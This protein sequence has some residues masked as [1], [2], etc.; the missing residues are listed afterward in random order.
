[1]YN[2]SCLAFLSNSFFIW[3]LRTTCICTAASSLLKNKVNFAVLNLPEVGS[4]DL[5]V[6]K[7][8]GAVHKQVS[9]VRKQTSSE[10]PLAQAHPTFA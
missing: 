2:Y 4:L 7:F 10:T 1:M 5:R 3:L 8:D 6:S 9:K